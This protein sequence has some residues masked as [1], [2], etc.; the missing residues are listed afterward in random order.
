LWISALVVAPFAEEAFFRGILQTALN[1]VVHHP[2][3][4]VLLTA[5]LFGLSHMAQPQAVP[6]LIVL[7]IAL[8]YVYERS[9]SLVAPV[10]LHV[11]FNLKNMIFFS[12]AGA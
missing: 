5:M 2:I 9:G 11:L 10:T 12:L 3:A 4:T 7:G 8:G 6:A 1:H